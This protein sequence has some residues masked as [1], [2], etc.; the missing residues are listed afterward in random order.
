MNSEDLTGA[1]VVGHDGSVEA[2]AA[3]RW[4][5]DDAVRRGTQLVVLRAW[6][7]K[8]TPRPVDA[9]PGYVPSE[10]EY[11]ASVRRALQA[12]VDQILGQPPGVEISLLVTHHPPRTALID[13]SS[14]A[15]LVVVA[16]R[17]RGLAK[18]VLGSTADHLTRHAQCPVVIVHSP[19]GEPGRSTVSM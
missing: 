13:A 17:G 8:S 3:V 9:E 4:A 5:R 14:T 16:P 18:A 12:D 2:A 1:V 15:A 19:G 7:M 10:D 11:A 6:T